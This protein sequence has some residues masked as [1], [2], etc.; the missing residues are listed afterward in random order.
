[1]RYNL[2]ESSRSERPE[3]NPREFS[4]KPILSYCIPVQD[5]TEDLRLT[6]RENLD[7]NRPRQSQVEFV[8]A[9]FDR[10]DELDCWMREAF[11]ADIASG[12]L[13]PKRADHLDP[14]HFGRAKNVFRD[15]IEG[16]IYSS[17]D[18]D[19]FV[20]PEETRQ[21]LDLH[22]EH[23]RNMLIHHFSGNWGDGT[24]G[25]VTLPADLYCTVGYDERALP[26]QFDEID[27]ILS[28]LRANPD[29]IY[30]SHF[31]GGALQKSKATA[32]FLRDEGIRLKTR[33]VADLRTAKPLN[34]KNKGYVDAFGFIGAMQRFNRASSFAKNASKADSKE[35]YFDEAMQAAQQA[36]AAQ[37]PA[38]ALQCFFDAP[39]R[40]LPR[41]DDGKVPVFACVKDDTFVLEEW[42]RH[43]SRIGCGPFFIIDDRSAVPVAETLPYRDVLTL[44]PRVGHY[45]T[46][47]S[48]WLMAAMKAVLPQDRWALTIDADEFVDVPLALGSTMADVAT[49]AA[50]RSWVPGVLVDM[51]P[52]ASGPSSD[53]ADASFLR[54]FDRHLLDKGGDSAAY[55]ANKSVRWAFGDAWH[56]SYRIDA[57]Y[58]LAG[59][60]DVLR[61]V[62]LVRYRHDISIHHG[63][64]DV[65]YAGQP[66]VRSDDW[67]GPLLLPMRH[68][69]LVK[70]F[71]SVERRRLAEH[72]QLSFVH[73]RK[74]TANL[75]TL[76][77]GD[78]SAAWGKL[79]TLETV[80][81]DPE[82]FSDPAF[83]RA[84]ST[85]GLG[86]RL[87]RRISAMRGKGEPRRTK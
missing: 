29:L 67:R 43:Y 4:M 18:A 39:A 73:D 45:R 82:R 52:A 15:L 9:N 78:Q 44:T 85:G 58:R 46:C 6:L 11:A 76:V 26:R 83:F 75:R 63:F 2:G 25:R 34:P 27:L 86:T 19:N 41:L 54:V 72:A 13:R 10:D 87:R 65:G 14:W 71:D 55:R 12:Y 51:L 31:A 79:L 49:A 61:K 3:A 66:K 74:T 47:K 35:R 30:I 60:V 48:A 8:V 33:V 20:S 53:A 59:T 1:M 36:I 69:K 5:R 70:L 68:Y 77:A 24:C 28:A 56:G 23:G 64:H 21:V 50:G 40:P 37:G 84:E 17:L 38:E 80:A 16:E 22:A 32:S 81:Y 62:P 57:R 42:Y 7:Q